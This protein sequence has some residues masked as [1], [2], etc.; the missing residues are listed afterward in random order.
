[1][2]SRGVNEILKVLEPWLST[3]YVEEACLDEKGWL[4]LQFTDGIKYIYRLDG[5]TKANAKELLANLRKKGIRIRK[6]NDISNT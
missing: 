2:K 5:Y 4:V 3:D 6:K 1:M